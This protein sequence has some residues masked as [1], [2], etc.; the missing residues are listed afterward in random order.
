MSRRP[1]RARI[2]VADDDEGVRELIAEVLAEK[3]HEVIAVKDAIEALAVLERSGDGIDL[4]V[5][6]IVMPGL[7]GFSLASLVKGRWPRVRILYITGYYDLARSDMGERFGSVLKK[8]FRPRQLS[9][10]V[11]RV[12][13][14]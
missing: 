8:P 4:L 13:A 3:G 11:T 9:A 5:T 2:L 7:N 10:E 14:A 6:D 1:D 12:L